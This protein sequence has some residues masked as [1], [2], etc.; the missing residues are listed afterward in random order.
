[1]LSLS[2]SLIPRPQRSADRIIE[3]ARALG[4]KAIELDFALSESTVEEVIALKG[5]WAIVISS[6]HHMCPLPGGIDPKRASPDTYN[7]ASSDVDERRLAVRTAQNT[8]RYAAKAG[9]RAVVLH[10]GSVEVR[11]R[12]K[13]L[14]ASSGEPARFALISAEMVRE[15]ATGAGAAVDRAI[16]SL[17]EIVPFAQDAGVLIGLENRYHYCDIP[18]G[19][20]FSAIFAAVDGARYWHDV[21]H[22]EALERL[23]LARHE[24][25]LKKHAGRLIGIHLHDIIGLTD[26]HH[27]PRC[28]TFDFSRLVPFVRD[29][30]IKVIEAHP[31]AT[32]DDVRRAREYLE[33]LFGGREG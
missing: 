19:D 33:G 7:L 15:R 17:G 14:A 25:L 22:A 16:A 4:F 5:R 32:G 23:D 29:D 31:P 27:A 1:M 24:E 13:E 3:E 26:D 20:E 30:T 6:L 2:T 21:G 9:A 11:D 10:A 28:G 8:I 12:T 18:L